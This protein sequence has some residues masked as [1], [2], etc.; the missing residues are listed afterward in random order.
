MSDS[1][2]RNCARSA[3]LRGNSMRLIF[4]NRFYWPETPATGQLL[5]DLAEFLA[6]SGHRVEVICSHPGTAGLPT[7]ETRNGVAIHRVR[8]SR[9]T[10][11]HLRNKAF[12]FGTF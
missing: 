10:N 3:R 5:T 11:T 1:P 6:A 8:S 2:R 12:D 9:S 4:V 7:D